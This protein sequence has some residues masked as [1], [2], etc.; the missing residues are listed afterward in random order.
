[1]M[2][3]LT[4]LKIG[5]RLMLAF[6][7]MLALT[8]VVGAFSVQR[9]GKVNGATQDLATNWLV[10][11][12]ALGEYRTD[13]AAVRRSEAIHLMSVK[14]EDMAAAD[15]GLVERKAKAQE[16]WK[17]Y[18]ST[19]AGED[20]RKVAKAVEDAQQAYYAD[21]DKVLGA[22]R[23]GEARKEEARELYRTLSLKSFNATM[24]AAARDVEFQTR[25]GDAAYA[26]SQADYASTRWAVIGLVLAALVV[27]MV[28]A[29]LITRSITV[30]IV[31]AVAVAETVAAGD[32]SS[33][34]KSGGS[35]ETG[36]LLAALKKMN[37]SLA[38]IVGQVRNSSDSIATGS[39]QIATGNADLSQRTE[40]QASNLQQTAAS[41]EQLT[42][43]VR[44]NADTARQ[45]TQLAGGASAAAAQGGDVVQQVVLTMG[46]IT[47]SSRRIAD[48][49]GTIDG[50]AF[51][52][53]I[54]ALNAAVEAARAGEQG[55]GFAV[56]A[57]EVRSLAQRS[58]A[59]AKEIK[60]LIGESVEKVENGS[61][62]V[63]AAGSSMGEIVSQVQRVNDLI[64]EISA[65]SVEQSSG[66][67]QIGDAVAQLDQVTQQNAALVEESAAAAESLRHQA[68]QLA[69]T[70][71]VFKLADTGFRAAAPAPEP[72]PAPAP[73]PAPRPAPVAPGK[74][75]ARKAT[76]AAVPATARAPAPAAAGA[77]E[78]W[79]SF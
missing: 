20:E 49:I 54:L 74:P 72:A 73:R 17:Q 42:A 76:P 4:R 19:V 77:E 71:A 39:T 41:M 9:I 38:G 23:A 44:Q 69:Q 33:D 10:A 63:N 40:E 35:D 28:L 50:I 13:I 37:D 45:A 61:R 22:S 59:A 8:F 51:Q 53:N 67:G 1:M 2:N 75:A 70:V 68:A 48:I 24:D 18:A 26:E 32:L 5:P 12:R 16:S 66:I 21:L 3:I 25:G 27:G 6:A 58:A 15:K 79:T 56:V 57:A 55:R 47:A 30:P 29:L 62:L 36:Q 78:A 60:Q 31:Q 52:T 7:V 34:V 14:A 43:T 65:A 64:S 46:E 11:M